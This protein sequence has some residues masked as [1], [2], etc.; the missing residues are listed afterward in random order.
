M[1][2]YQQNPDPGKS[3]PIGQFQSLEGGPVMQEMLILVDR[4]DR[5]I[6]SGT[7]LHV[8]QSGALH[9][10]FSI[11]IFDR[12]GKLLLQR[13]ALDKYHSAGLWSNSCCGHPRP[14]EDTDAAA[15]RRLQEEMGFDCGLRK[16]LALIYHASLS[17]GLIE[18]EYDHVYLGRF[19]G[20]PNPDPQEALDWRW[21]E[22]AEVLAWMADRPDDFTI[23]FKR[24]L[25]HISP[26]GLGHWAA[27]AQQQPQS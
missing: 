9:R 7:K 15:H 21:S 22:P 23:W 17:G 25:E 27:L 18:H 3:T 20:D 14:G 4:E 6:G 1:Y 13:R 19:D 26:V 10:A 11:L 8:H 5:P 24:I 2:Q 12:L 16:V